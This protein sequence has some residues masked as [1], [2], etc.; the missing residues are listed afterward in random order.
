M[1]FP[2]HSKL[3]GIAM[4]LWLANYWAVVWW[5]GRPV[6][7]CWLAPVTATVFGPWQQLLLLLT[8]GYALYAM[9]RYGLMG[10]IPAFGGM[11]LLGGAGD[12]ARTLLFATEKS[13]G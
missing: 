11:V 9:V 5:P 10:A 8:C 1:T 3:L 6:V 2:R 12:F 13:C 7:Y 4:L